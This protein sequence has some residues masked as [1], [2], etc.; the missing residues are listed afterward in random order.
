MVRH[1]KGWKSRL[2]GGAPSVEK[3]S[4]RLAADVTQPITVV[5]RPVEELNQIR[6]VGD[7]A[8]HPDYT[9]PEWMTGQR[10]WAQ[11]PIARAVGE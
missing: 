6:I 7:D 3:I 8:L 10:E 9:D 11:L 2:R 4:D 1:R 5:S